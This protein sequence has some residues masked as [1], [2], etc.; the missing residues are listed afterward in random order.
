MSRWYCGNLMA[1]ALALLTGCAAPPAAV[2]PGEAVTQLRTGQPLMSC[3]EGCVGEWQRAQPQA[4]QLAA[5]GR[6]ADLAALTLRVGYQDDLSLYY[7]GQAAEGLGY[8]GAAA[9]YYRQSTYLSGTT[10]ACQNL[11]HVCGGVVFPRAALL[12]LAAI[13]RS[14]Y[15]PRGRRLMPMAPGRELPII[16]PDETVPPPVEVGVPLSAEPAEPLPMPVPMPAPV[17]TPAPA[18]APAPVRPATSDYIEPPPA[19]R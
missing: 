17:A 18:V 19:S 9:S 8:P 13:D 10:I 15:R 3:R 1:M 4:A 7:L 16:A 11:S 5:A 2:T 14:L 12:R 6:W